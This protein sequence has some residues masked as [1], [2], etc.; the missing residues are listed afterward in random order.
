MMWPAVLYVAFA[1]I[2]SVPTRCGHIKSGDPP[3]FV[4]SDTLMTAPSRPIIEL[5]SP[6]QTALKWVLLT[7]PYNYDQTVNASLLLRFLT[8]KTSAKCQF[9]HSMYKKSH[10]KKPRKSGLFRA[11]VRLY[12]ISAKVYFIF[13]T[14]HIREFYRKK[15]TNVQKS[16]KYNVIASFFLC[17]FL[18]TFFVHFQKRTKTCKPFYSGTV[19]FGQD[20]QAACPAHIVRFG[21]CV[22]CKSIRDKGL[23]DLRGIQHPDPSRPAP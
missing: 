22:A 18:C 23:C 15:C 16:V 21:L 5:N 4:R 8:R 2:R 1:P 12:K 11:F 17:T 20:T 3:C 19:Q 6:C 10:S 7:A 9:V 14:S 13:L